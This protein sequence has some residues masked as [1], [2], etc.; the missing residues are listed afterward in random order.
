MVALVHKILNKE[1]SNFQFVQA[2]RTDDHVDCTGYGNIKIIILYFVKVEKIVVRNI[3]DTV[4]MSSTNDYVITSGMSRYNG[5][6]TKSK[7]KSTDAVDSS[8][9]KSR[10]RPRSTATA[11]A[12]TSTRT[13]ND[14]TSSGRRQ[15]AEEFVDE[16]AEAAHYVLQEGVRFLIGFKSF[17]LSAATTVTDTTATSSTTTST[18]PPVMVTIPAAAM[19]WLE[20]SLHLLMRKGSSPK[21]NAHTNGGTSR[22]SSSSS[23]MEHLIRLRNQLLLDLKPYIATVTHLQIIGTPWPNNSNSSFTSRCP[24][25]HPRINVQLFPSV[26]VLILDAIPPEWLILEQTTA[27]QLTLFKVQRACVYDVYSLFHRTSFHYF[28]TLTHLRLSECAIGELSGL[29]FETSS[30]LP[31]CCTDTTT[32][33]TNASEVVTTTPP[34]F[35]QMPN[36]KSINLRKNQIIRVETAVAG[37]KSLLKL[38]KVDLSHNYIKR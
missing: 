30:P 1:T 9:I 5:G 6:S 19:D 21:K 33:K 26:Q 13:S 29:V 15:V 37:F 8:V 38:Q 27:S 22:I 36:L 28:P 7:N 35:S 34:I 23:Y 10:I 25:T 14:G 24:Y 11:T 2:K 32:T 3:Y 31:Q 4:E 12:S 17:L 16:G 18:S 20:A